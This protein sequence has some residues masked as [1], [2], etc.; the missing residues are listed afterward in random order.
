[1]LAKEEHVNLV[2]YG[3]TLNAK[4]STPPIEPVLIQT[5]E[6]TTVTGILETTFVMLILIS[7]IG[8]YQLSDHS[9]LFWL[10]IEFL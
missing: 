10:Q 3:Y 9:N 2:S 1:M 4:L 8:F 5:P 7:M 6:S